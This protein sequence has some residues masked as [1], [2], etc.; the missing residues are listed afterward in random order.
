MGAYIDAFG[1][2]EATTRLNPPSSLRK[3]DLEFENRTPALKNSKQ[4][5]GVDEDVQL[6]AP[7]VKTLAADG[8]AGGR[9]T[10]GMMLV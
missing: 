6:F 4:N 3:L 10:G 9:L 2:D 8:L 1:L 7:A 5:A